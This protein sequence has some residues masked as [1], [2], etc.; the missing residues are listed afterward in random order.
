MRRVWLTCTYTGKPFKNMEIWLLSKI[1]EPGT[2]IGKGARHDANCNSENLYLHV[3]YFYYFCFRGKAIYDACVTITSVFTSRPAIAKRSNIHA[4]MRMH[5]SFPAYRA[6]YHNII[7]ACFYSLGFVC[8]LVLQRPHFIL[9]FR[10]TFQNQ[11]HTRINRQASLDFEKQNTAP[12]D[13]IR[14]LLG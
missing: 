8:L 4:P 10:I 6:H 14:E 9:S 2:G 11:P 3:L 1:H 12:R 5:S 13:P 7:K